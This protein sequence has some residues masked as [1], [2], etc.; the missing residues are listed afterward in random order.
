MS[1]FCPICHRPK[2]EEEL[3]C[4]DCK[5]KIKDEYEVFVPEGSASPVIPENEGI[6]DVEAI[7]NV[8]GDNPV[9]EKPDDNRSAQKDEPVVYDEIPP[10]VK[11][12]TPPHYEAVGEQPKKKKS[13]KLLWILFAM[14]LL[15]GAFY[16]YMQYVQRQNIERSAW[17]TASRENSV[18]GYLAYMNEFPDGKYFSEAQEKMLTLKNS[19]TGLWEKLRSSQNVTEFQDF[20]KKFPESPYKS[21]VR[22]RL[23]SLTWVATLNSNTAQAYSDYMVSSD[24]GELPGNN[25]ADAQERYEMLFQTYPVDVEQQDSIKRTV[26]GFYTALSTVNYPKINEYLAPMVNR[27]FNSGAATREKITGELLVAAAKT[28]VATIKFVPDITSL[29]YQKTFNGRYKANVPLAKTYVN[30][31]GQTETTYGYIVHV[32]L[33]DNFRIIGIYETKPYTGAV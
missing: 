21:L 12:V 31:E 11:P 5:K 22:D 29:Q 8:A 13:R 25:Y 19:E 24:S 6:T 33:D 27:F 32:E 7:D 4:E 3:F 18:N 28:Q 9:S 20:L 30:K 17:E 10:A 1:Q 26:D 16:V 23:D 15:V 2:S 14:A